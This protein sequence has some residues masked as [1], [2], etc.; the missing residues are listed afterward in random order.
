VLPNKINRTRSW[1]HSLFQ[2]LH[3]NYKNTKQCSSFQNSK[4]LTHLFIHEKGTAKSLSLSLSLTAKSYSLLPHHRSHSRRTTA[5]TLSPS[6]RTTALTLAA[7]LLSLSLPLAADLIW[8][9]QSLFYVSVSVKL[10]WNLLSC[11]C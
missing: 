6:G 10:F 7:P 3:S 11:F 4:T 8:G 9:K 2:T 1:L 5:L